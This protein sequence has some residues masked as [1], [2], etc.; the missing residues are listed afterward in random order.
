[1]FIVLAIRPKIPEFKAGR[2]RWTFKSDKIHCMTSFGGKV[3][4]SAQSRKN[5]P[6]ECDRDTSLAKTKDI[7]CQI[8]PASIIGVSA[9]TCQR[10]LVDE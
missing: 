7:S 10:A 5:I 3:K 6:A 8:S 1:V 9:G 2:G 4:P